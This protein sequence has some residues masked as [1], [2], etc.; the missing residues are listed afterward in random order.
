MHYVYLLECSDKTIYCGYTNNLELR[1]KTHNNGKG[2]KYTKCRLPVRIVYSQS[3]D[4]KSEAL[5]RECE[6]KKFTREL[7]L[8]LINNMK[9]S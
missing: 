9:Q 4:T 8:Q 6:I 2:A 1:L 5:K 7:K 3:F